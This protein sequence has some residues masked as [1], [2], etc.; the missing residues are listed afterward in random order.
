MGSQSLK[1]LSNWTEL[2]NGGTSNK[3]KGDWRWSPYLLTSDWVKGS[4]IPPSWDA[5]ACH[6]LSKLPAC[7]PGTIVEQVTESWTCMEVCL[8][9]I[10]S[11]V[12]GISPP[13]FREKKK[14]KRMF[15]EERKAQVLGCSLLGC[16]WRH[17][18]AWQPP[19]LYRLFLSLSLP[20][21]PSFFPL[22]PLLL[23]PGCV[24]S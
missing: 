24:Y 1:R 5:A 17:L 23:M 4:V 2:M 15:R 12:H 9:I 10:L 6:K 16:L 14:L 13:E 3:A 19:S 7:I 11:K 21:P 20:L 22:P 8:F 18:V